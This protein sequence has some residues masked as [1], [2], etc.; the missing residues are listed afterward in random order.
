MLVRSLTMLS[1]SGQRL[2]GCIAN[3][4]AYSACVL[5]LRANTQRASLTKRANFFAKTP[6]EPSPALEAQSAWC[7]SSV[8]FVQECSGRR[9][10]GA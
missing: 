4:Q 3:T 9:S 10:P 2:M 1:N 7:S 6:L 5:Q 8:D